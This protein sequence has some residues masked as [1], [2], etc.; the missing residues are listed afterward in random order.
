MNTRIHPHRPQYTTPTLPLCYSPVHNSLVR[1]FVRSSIHSLLQK[2]VNAR[3]H[4]A[5]HDTT[6]HTPYHMNT[7][8][9]SRAPI[10][11]YPHPS[12]VQK[13]RNSWLSLPS[14][15]LPSTCTRT[16]TDYTSCASIARVTP[17]LIVSSVAA[18]AGGGVGG[19]EGTA[20][21]AS[22][23]AP[24][25]PCC[26]CCCSWVVVGGSGSLDGS[27]M[28]TALSAPALSFSLF[29]GC[30]MPLEFCLC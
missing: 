30:A 16:R 14:S 3:R 7:S 10:P 13:Q 5:Q 8:R 2:Q 20:V 19:A 12:Q 27:S 23:P 29:L 17:R 6:R 26:C 28:S 21:H 22:G 18:E 1:S 24:D 11:I 9:R 15:P 4:T 25:A